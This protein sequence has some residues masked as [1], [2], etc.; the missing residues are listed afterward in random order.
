MWT[1]SARYWTHRKAIG[2]SPRFMRCVNRSDHQQIINSFSVNL[3]IQ[4]DKR[5]YNTNNNNWVEHNDDISTIIRLV[6][7]VVSNNFCVLVGWWQ[8]MTSKYAPNRQ[9]TNIL[10]TFLIYGHFKCPTLTKQY[11]TLITT[12]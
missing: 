5:P 4:N 7:I 2:K 9:S 11:L 12:E 6:V 1:I 8:C 10:H 3:L